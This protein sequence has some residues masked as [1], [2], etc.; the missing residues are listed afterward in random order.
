MWYSVTAARTDRTGTQ[1][2]I[3]KKVETEDLLQEGNNP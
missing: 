2:N 1:G 3:K